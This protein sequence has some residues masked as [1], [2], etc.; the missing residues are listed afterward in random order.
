[1][2]FDQNYMSKDLRQIH[3]ARNLSEEPR[4]AATAS[5]T[6]VP[7]MAT[8][9]AANT[10]RNPE[11]FANPDGSVPVY[12]P[13]TVS[14]AGFI[15]L[16]Y[17]NPVPGV[18]PWAQRIPL[19]I[20]SVN[21]GVNGPAG[22]G[23]GYNP[24]LG[25]RVVSNAVDRA[26]N[27]LATG[28]GNV[29]HLGNRV[30]LNG[31]NEL[32]SPGCG[33]NSN[34][35]SRGSA[36]GSGS[37]VD[38]AS[39]EG[40]DD[41]VSGK[42]VK[43]LC[44]FGGKILP[45]PS[46]GTLRYVGG[47]TRII[48]LRRDV[49]FN[50]LVQKMVDTYGQPAVIKYQLP[51]EDLDALVSV[52]CPDDLDN[53]MD[54]Y[55]KLAERSSDG[56]AKLRVFLFSAMELDSSG[57]VQFGDLHDSGQRY[58]D[59]I[60]GMEGGFGGIARKGSITSATSTQNSDF[61]VTEAVDSLGPGQVD[62]SGA[63]T[64]QDSNPKFLP[65]EPNPVSTV[66][67]GIPM[68]KS[69]P[70]Q[71]L[72]SQP[73]IEFERSVPVTVSQQQVGYDFQQAGMGI[74]LSAP[75][76]QAYVDRQE[77]TNMHLPTQMRFPNAQIR[78]NQQQIPDSNSGVA[79]HQFIPTVHMTMAPASSPS[80]VAMRPTMVQP[81]VQPQQ[82]HLEHY[83]DENSFGSR[84]VQL[85]LDPSY[86]A[87]QSQFS[88]PIVGG[89][90]TWHPIPQTEH[91]VFSDGS[92]P[93]QHVIFPEKIQRLDDCFM[94]QKALPHAH[95]DPLAHDQRESGVSPLSDSNS[96]HLSLHLGDA[97]KV[98]TFNRGMGGLGDGIVEQT[99]G[100]RPSV[101]SHVDH[102]IGLK[103]SEP[104][105]FCQNL[106]SLHEDERSAMQ[107]SDNSVPGFTGAVT[108]PHQ[109]ESRQQH[110][111]IGQ[112]RVNEEALFNKPINSDSPHF[113]GAIQGTERMAHESPVD[114]SGKLPLNVSKENIVDANVSNDQLSPIEGMMENL[115][116]CPLEMTGRDAIL[117][118][119]LHKPQVVLDSNHIKQ[120]K[121]LPVSTEAS[122]LYNSRLMESYEVA[123]PS[124]LGNQGPYPQS[125]IGINLLDSDEISYGN[126]TFLGAET[127]YSPNMPSSLSSSSR[128]VDVHDSPNSL[129]SSQDPWSLR[130]DAH[131]PPPRPNKILTKKETFDTK[132]PFSENYLSNAGE[133]V[134]GRLLGDGV[135]ET[136][137]NAKSEQDQSFQEELIK[138]EL[139]AVAEDVVASVFQSVNVSTDSLVEKHESACQDKEVSVKDAEMHHK[140]KFE[141]MKSK[142]P[143]KVS[144]GFPVSE[145]IGRLQIIKNSDLEELQ[146]LG[147]GTFGTVYHG[148]W[149]GSDVAIKR[150]NDRC[151]AGKPS[152]QDRMIEDFWNEAIKLADL[153]HP[154][155]V[156]F[157][158][159]VLD[160]PGR[161]V[162]TVTEY[163]VNGSLRNAL[164]K[165][166][167]SLDKR[168]RLLIAM[169]V[170]FGMEYLHGK[171]IVHFD[172]K[173][174]NLLVNLRDPHRP[175]CKVGDLGL[176]KVKRQTLIS[177]GVRG[178]LPWMAPELLNGSSSLVS[179]KVDVFSFGVVLWEL[180]TGEEPYADLHYGAIIGGIVSNT[181]RPPVPESCDP[182]WRSLMER[183]WS[184]EPS[185]RP[186]FTEIA[187]AL[188]AMATKIPPKGQ[189]STQQL[190]STQPQVQS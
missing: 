27:D 116:A 54:E 124:I 6:S 152:E 14:D 89:G 70:P 57:M 173:S 101:P 13:A 98:Q 97:T 104:A 26:G 82:N 144:I 181:L 47:Q 120:P 35:G 21:V 18:P 61:S 168:K 3:V 174:D 90:Y 48:S 16:G 85:P 94:C 49:S 79:P 107:K 12:Y 164:Q 153:H 143:E 188:R 100:A 157:Y 58:V 112:Y 172:L 74:P 162:A 137:I 5:T 1:M 183:C 122:Y 2:A 80:H 55:E 189:N 4:I 130:H 169:D 136:L 184:S 96:V 44:S 139:Q 128:L 177:G 23:F 36:S 176:S 182:E 40:G 8:T 186:N 59:A 10:I 155:V 53:M 140:A 149:R 30:N 64:P 142:L 148:K 41:S 170:A 161:S 72:S 179:E 50:E 22:V 185:E 113:A 115:R 81:L 125:N 126:P 180:L 111:V 52:S 132:D 190:P 146:E 88:T 7:T 151:F 154:N 62:V 106:E 19:P 75:H 158:G 84:I 110:L 20:G 119:T 68:V 76:L 178:T 167:R 63:P 71:N 105:I 159:V 93:H 87:Y 69:V 131:L 46:D 37:A 117:D 165:N 147:S 78:F 129:F 163:M 156:A 108:Q 28:L 38:H 9:T 114:Y 86:S 141:D 34:L 175:I 17:A 150:I 145:G 171:N 135:S 43:F 160:G 91:V 166:E 11:I 187:N 102:Q 73:E 29:N 121:V 65:V 24:N 103:Q 133:L 66:S 95:S 42:K 51:D 45:R 134:A 92:M 60:N 77:V 109:E 138:Q 56:S 118:N 127:A 99:V 123:Q 39:E 31:S 33:Y 83:S 15:G 32:T 25:N 67:S